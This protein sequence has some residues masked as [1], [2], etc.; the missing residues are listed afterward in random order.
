MS[1]GLNSSVTKQ[2]WVSSRLLGGRYLINQ[3]FVRDAMLLQCL[4]ILFPRMIHSFTCAGVLPSQY[5]HLCA[6]ANLGNVGSRYIAS[7][8]TLTNTLLQSITRVVT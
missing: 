6:N 8:T 7:G 3:K 1:Y 4:L 5:I 2:W